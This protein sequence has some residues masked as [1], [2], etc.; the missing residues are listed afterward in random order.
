MTGVFR[1]AGRVVL[2]IAALLAPAA[3]TNAQDAPD[4]RPAF[5]LS[6]GT[7]FTTADTPAVYLTFRN[8]EG[9]DFRVYRVQDPV[10]FLAGLEDPHQLGSERPLVPQAPTLLER[11][12]TWKA[13]WRSRIRS[14]VRSQ[15][16]SDYRRARRER[17]DASAVV[18]R[19]QTTRARSFA[20]V[21]LLNP[22]QLVTS[23]HEILPRLRDTDVRRIPIDTRE[24]GLY[25]VEAV[26]PPYRAYTI[27]VV[28]DIGLVSK[29]A[30]GQLLLYA[31][32]RFT[33]APAAGCRVQVLADRQPIA[34]GTTDADG[35]FEAQPAAG[36]DSYVSIARCGDQVTIA[37]PG[38][39]YLREAAREL[40]GYVFTDKPIYRPGHTV[41]V[42]GF[43]RWRTHGALV[44]FDAGEVEVRVSDLTQKVIYRE[45]RP[46]DAFGGVTA[47]IPLGPGVAL[48]H[49]VIAI[50][51]GDE[52][53]TAG[54]EVQE[55]RKPEFEVIVRAEQPFVV[56][57][58]GITATIDARYY[59]G[60]PV[61]NGRVAWVAHKQPYYSP[62]RWS[63]DEDEFGGGYWYG[64]EQT[65]QGE[66]R[67]GP[68]GRATIVVPTEPDDDRRDYSLRIEARVTDAGGREVSGSRVVHATI[69]TFL[70]AASTDRYLIRPG[71]T[72]TLRVRAVSYQG[73]PKA[74]LPVQVALQRRL[75]TYGWEDERGVQ[76]VTSATI[77]TDANGDASWVVPTPQEPG[78]YRIRAR[79]MEK[80][81][82]IEDDAYVWRPGGRADEEGLSDEYRYLEL[83]PERRT[84][85]P[86]EIAR[87]LIRGA[88][89]DAHVLVTKEADHVSWRQVIQARGNGT[90]E[91]PIT[92]EDVGDVWV[93]LV[94][95]Q[96]KRLYRAE[97]RVRVP[98]VS[99][100]ITVTITPEAE[101][102]RPREPAR[103]RVKAVDAT[104]AP[105]RAQFGLGV[106]DE[107]VY[108]VKPDNTADPLQY[109]YRRSYSRVG[110]QFSREY[111]F[112]GY[113][114]T[115]VLRLAQ[116]RR[117]YSLADF[118]ADKPAQPQVRKEFPDAIYWIGDLVTDANGE[119][120][121][122]LTY[123]DAL[124]TWRVTARGVT[125]DTKAG[126]AVAR[127]TVTKDLIV[128]PIT[129]RFLVE[130]DR[131]TVPV[132][133]HNYQ[134]GT[135]TARVELDAA[136]LTV[137][138]APA[139]TEAAI[140]SGGDV[141]LDWKV[142]AGTAGTATVTARATTEAAADAVELSFPVQPFGLQRET[143]SSGS[144]R[145][146]STASAQLT[147]P[148]DT[149]PAARTISVRLAPSL[150]GS[151][152]G[153]L[154]FLTG[155]PYGCTEQTLSRFLPTLVVQRAMTQLGLQ[156]TERL[157]LVDR[158]VTAGVAR[159][160]EYQHDDG[161]WGWWRTDENHPF[162]T[163]YAV[164]GLLE[165][166]QNGYHVDEWR[167]R[168]GLNAM[169]E[170]YREYPRAVPAL[171]AYMLFVLARASAAGLEPTP[172]DE[173]FDRAAA[174]DEVW[175]ARDRLT[176][177]GRALLLLAFDAL[178][179]PRGD[180]L[181]RTLAG[182]A[183]RRGDLAW[184]TVGRDPLLDDWS[185][186]S[187][188]ATAMAVQALAPRMPSDPLLEQAVRYILARRQAGAW[189]STK[190]TAM[191]V[192]GLTAYMTARGERASPVSVE[193]AVNGA[194]VQTV[195][196]EADDIT[197]PDPVVV[198]APAREGE[199]AV[200]L[201][202]T[203]EGTV[204]WS[205]SA[206][207][208]ET[209]TPI[210]RTGGRELAIAREYF[211]LTPQRVRDRI[212]YRQVPFDGAASPGDVLLVRL[213]VAGASD[214]RYL[215]IED[216][217][218]AGSEAMADDSLYEL[219]RPLA[220]SW[221]NRR[222][223]RDDRVVFFQDG[224]PGGR[225]EF[226]Y[227]LKITS[228]GVFTALPARVTPMYVPDVMAST[229]PEMVTIANGGAQ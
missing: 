107:A 33:G 31:A 122:T 63:D 116:K 202:V 21:P 74:N 138:G 143:G 135:A 142:E 81:R 128:R 60:Q 20:Q 209:R 175:N 212:V 121:V 171:K 38:G 28:S 164:Y 46:V 177:Y 189:M 186:T 123:P 139:S 55:Y 9:L 24:P 181:A 48:G 223:L 195:A 80:G 161:G 187:V 198:T 176:P 127:T 183:E 215:L 66:T 129:P 71:E 90:I 37:D 89:F 216:P 114:G 105:V 49:Y 79:A 117:P 148:A 73:E 204:Y 110:T 214:W 82:A 206:R 64:D 34:S 167:I 163:A 58:T 85:M 152:L 43:L 222:E 57:G 207:Y 174:L 19:R 217:L 83:I 166:R 68:D 40:I 92:E 226:W 108:G 7:I 185:D 4:D 97:R 75:A 94:F 160:L 50:L 119:A 179:D 59:F 219:E 228:P 199:N 227:L 100:A 150:A 72:T 221:R 27:V 35:L 12:A 13:R 144:A 136:N 184:W 70:I 106:I 99:R 44:P 95:M 224:L 11:I 103:F 140:P 149:N 130:G 1:H 180:E 25:V 153:A 193:V 88:E 23:W 102:A 213:T 67:L 197:A 201:T 111:Y 56:Q 188:E 6:S 169:V 36:H 5:S 32:D 132:V 125:A 211:S 141:R 61:A 62:L 86:G 17:L 65:L 159:L 42:K 147:V 29:A 115:E 84:V 2:V 170:Q 69:G 134:D 158:Q 76:E 157:S 14:F 52:T 192:Y 54:F 87:F 77:T 47:D 182:E 91:V 229:T 26:S 51:H 196:F 155:Y 101:T 93:N 118:K 53:A 10:A 151:L 178:K 98:A 109:F 173:P 190:A 168:R 45:R 225:V 133:T 18:L 30:P 218:P 200:T 208:F 165:T 112:V 78:D 124:T 96:E 194:P 220:G 3:A 41:H 146:G 15:F 113:S 120:M 137:T 145:G 126:Q 205:A 210:A 22:S 156:A 203:G 172:G 154:D 16:S 8:L 104:G 39:W 131:L 191:A 162:M